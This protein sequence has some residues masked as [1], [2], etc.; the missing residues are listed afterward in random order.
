MNTQ[1]SNLRIK[2]IFYDF[3]DKLIFNEYGTFGNKYFLKPIA[4]YFKV[5]VQI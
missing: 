4:K 1:S 3:T 5:K 2:K